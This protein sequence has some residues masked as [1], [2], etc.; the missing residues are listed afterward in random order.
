MRTDVFTR[1]RIPTGFTLVEVVIVLIVIAVLSTLLT[2]ALLRE[3]EMARRV[4][5]ARNLS[6]IGRACYTYADENRDMLPVA[7]H[8]PATQDTVG[9]VDYTRAIG[10]YR[11]RADDKEAGNTA[12]MAPPPSKLSTTRNLWILDRIIRHAR[13]KPGFKLTTRTFICPSSNDKPIDQNH[14]D[15]DSDIYWDFGSGDITGPATREQA[16]QGWSQISYG[17]AI[18]YGKHAQPSADWDKNSWVADKGPYGAAIEAGLPAPPPIPDPIPR[19]ARDWRPWNSPNH[20][21][22]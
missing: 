6:D 20:N 19:R 22:E 7:A 14:S 15:A 12:L 10:S 3:R 4:A 5:C 1:R 21:H 16:R 2:F 18:P 17:Y 9:L 13:Y 8:T 11:G